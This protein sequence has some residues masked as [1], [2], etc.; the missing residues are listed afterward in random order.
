MSK[1]YKE[2][3]L[4]DVK[5]E[6]MI[7]MIKQGIPPSSKKKSFVP[8]VAPLFALVS[9]FLFFLTTSN[10][11]GQL[12]TSEGVDITEVTHEIFILETIILWSV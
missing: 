4:S 5:K 12:V 6:R 3:K 8:I 7:Q 11:S 9:V 2:L 10:H 1:T